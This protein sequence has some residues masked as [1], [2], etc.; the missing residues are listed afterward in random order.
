MRSADAARAA[1]AERADPVH[2]LFDEFTGSEASG[3]VEELT[4]KEPV[5]EEPGP[6]A[7]PVGV[8]G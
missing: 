6:S 7:P 1:V 8:C 2:T 5:P 4:K 3:L